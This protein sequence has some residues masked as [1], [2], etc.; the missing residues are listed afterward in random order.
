MSRQYAKKQYI[1]KKKPLLSRK[2]RRRIFHAMTWAMIVAT[3]LLA[4]F[5]FAPVFVRIGQA[6]QDLGLSLWYYGAFFADVH[7]SVPTTVQNIP[8]NIDILL[9]VTLEEIKAFLERF[10]ALF[11]NADNFKIYCAKVGK[12]V[13]DVSQIM[14]IFSLPSLAYIIV[15]WLFYRDVPKIQRK[16]DSKPLKLF[17]KIRRKTLER[18]QGFFR[19]YVGFLRRKRKL[20]GRILK[21]LWAYNLNVITIGIEAIAWIF[22]FAVSSDLL[23]IFPQ[24]AKLVFDISVSVFFFPW[25]A[26]AIIIFK[27][28]DFFRHGIGEKRVYKFVEKVE[29][30]LEKHPGAKFIVGKQ[31]SKKTSLL[32]LFKMILERF[33]RKQAEKRI[34]IR[35]KQ[36]PH[37]RWQSIRDAVEYGRRKGTFKVFDDMTLFAATIEDAYNSRNEKACE[38]RR[39]KKEIKKKYGYNISEFLGFASS[40]PIEYNN[41]SVVVS[42]FDAIE[43]YSQLFFIY[44]Q[45]T[46]LDISNYSIREDFTFKDH[47]GYPIF[48]GKFLRDPKESAKYTQYSHIM[49][50][51]IF[52]P[53]K[54]FDEATRFDETVE[55]GIGT[56]TEFAKERKNKVSKQGIKKE[57]AKANQNN[58]NFELDCKVRGQFATIDYFDFW[59]EIVDDQRP[60]ALGAD[61]KD[62]MTTIRIKETK[63]AKVVFPFF[64][65]EA[66][67]CE[68]IN[69]IWDKV[70]YFIENRK[71]MSTLLVYIVDMLGAPFFRRLDRI[72]KRYGVHKVITKVQDGM[73]NEVL[74]EADTLYIPVGVVYNER[75]ATDCC[76]SFATRRNAKAKRT[77][78]A[79]EQYDRLHPTQEQYK[80][81]RS[82]FVE[83]MNYGYGEER[84]QT[85]PQEAKKR[86]RKPKTAQA[87]KE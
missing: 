73:D 48:D 26:W 52:R 31:R 65:L 16:R 71:R 7:E 15:A 61:N 30:W 34:K 84:F 5:R 28:V 49:N 27:V 11:R 56:W 69:S 17:K 85:P 24:I 20:Y 53:G 54:V 10:W 77:L 29:Q 86:G 1:P 37:F 41:G 9:P 67:F 45:R 2:A 82:Y 14:I 64:T 79:I 35:A 36:F 58:D 74:G 33:F 66:G 68:F 21:W 3:V 55:Y 12:L 44:N 76:R 80:K 22:W 63:D 4:V 32:T 13:A 42:I 78:N 59:A 23:N 75:F 50:N 8:E 87:T 39:R 46:P 62:L 38:R 19:K 70:K 57:D 40:Y 51:D 25:W 60:D 43:K 83:D 6:F 81:Q 18:T 47:G 72:E